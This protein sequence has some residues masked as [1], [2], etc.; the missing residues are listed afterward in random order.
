MMNPQPKHKTPRNQ[1]Y[2]FWIRSKP[3][4]TIFKYETEYVCKL[5]EKQKTILDGISGIGETPILA[6][7]EWCIA[8]NGAVDVLIEDGYEIVL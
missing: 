6:L 1:E 7:K 2:L 4:L 5:N 3:C 8:M